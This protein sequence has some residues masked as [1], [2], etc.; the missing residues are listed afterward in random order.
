VKLERLCYDIH[1]ALLV[2]LA[3]FSGT[4]TFDIPWQFAG[5]GALAEAASSRYRLLRRHCEAS[6][7]DESSKKASA[8]PPRPDDL[9]RGYLFVLLKIEYGQ[10]LMHTNGV[11]NE[12]APEESA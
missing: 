11:N 7:W 12:E 4:L 8:L 10:N 5:R 9:L 6:P 3:A 2:F 1:A